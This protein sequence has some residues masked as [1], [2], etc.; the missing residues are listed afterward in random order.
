MGF[1]VVIIGGTYGEIFSPT[2]AAAASVAYVLSPIF[3]PY[4]VSTGIDTVLLGHDGVPPNGRRIR[5]TVFWTRYFYSP[6][7]FQKTLF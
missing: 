7:Y 5:H 2:E 3:Q 4:V 6:A 1:P